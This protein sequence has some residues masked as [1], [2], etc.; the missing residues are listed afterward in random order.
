MRTNDEILKNPYL[1]EVKMAYDGGKGEIHVGGWNGSII[2]SIGAGWE[3]VSVSPYAKRTMPTW[4]DM[5]TIKNIF[6]NEDEAV[7]QVH[8]AKAE[9]VNMVENC[10]HLWRC[11][12][13]EMVLPPSILVGIRPGMTSDDIFKEV[14]A[15][16]ELAGEK[17]PWAY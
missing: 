8:P 12:Y 1:R 2:W 15:A 17:Y 14:Q 7:I 11:T 10:L 6:W 9:Y 16:Y 13:K 5:C 3:H 4:D